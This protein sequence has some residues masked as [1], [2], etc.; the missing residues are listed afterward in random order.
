MSQEENRRKL[1][2]E[3]IVTAKKLKF[4]VVAVPREMTVFLNCEGDVSI[5][6][7]PLE[8]HGCQTFFEALRIAAQAGLFVQTTQYLP[9]AKNGKEIVIHYCW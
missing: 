2:T 8:V 6:G 4:L 5:N 1:R 9:P 7:N 3:L